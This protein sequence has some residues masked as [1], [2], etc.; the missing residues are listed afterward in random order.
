MAASY[1]IKAKRISSETP[2]DIDGFDN[3]EDDIDHITNFERI[4]QIDIL[5]GLIQRL[6]PGDRQVITLYLEDIDAKDNRI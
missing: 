1:V 6:K 3:L 5:M 4:D 2:I